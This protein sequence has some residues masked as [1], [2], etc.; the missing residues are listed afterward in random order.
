MFGIKKEIF[1][2]K[3]KKKILGAA[4]KIERV[5][6]FLKRVKNPDIGVNKKTGQIVLKNTQNASETIQT[7]L[8]IEKFIP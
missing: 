8:L 7:N 6:K 4:T 2:L 3:I 1:H 5:N